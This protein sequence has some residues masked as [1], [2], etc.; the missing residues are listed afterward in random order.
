MGRSAARCHPG[1]S[2][3]SRWRDSGRGGPYRLSLPQGPE[4]S[5]PLVLL[6]MAETRN[7]RGDL[8]SRVVTGCCCR[9]LRS[10]R[11]RWCWCGWGCRAGLR[12]ST[13]C[14][15][16]AQTPTIRSS[17]IS[18][19]GVPEEVRPLIVGFNEMMGRLEENLQAQQRFIA[20]AAHQM[21]TPLTGLRTQTELALQETEPRQLRRSLEQIAGSAERESPHQ[22]VAVAGAPSPAREN[23]RR[24]TARSQ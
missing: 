19:V 17:P 23:I 22:S 12:R 9:S 6:Q 5:S 4:P 7:K 15:E 1:R 24:G 14:N 2:A 8:A 11:S 20:D 13:G 18:T 10:S 3:V 21:R 16:P